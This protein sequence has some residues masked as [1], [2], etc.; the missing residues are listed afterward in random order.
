[1]A[2]FRRPPRRG[3]VRYEENALQRFFRIVL[4]GLL[5]TGVLWG[6]WMN[7]ERQ[8]NRVMQNAAPRIDATGTLSPAQLELL[9]TYGLRF[10]AEYGIR[11]QVEVRNSALSEAQAKKTGSMYLGLNPQSGQALFYAPPLAAAAL[12]EEFIRRLNQEHFSAYFAAGNW[13]QG[14]AEALSMI[15][16]R[17]DATLKNAGAGPADNSTATENREQ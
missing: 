12:G 13:P 7:S 9:Q 3:R 14:L 2:L 1:M 17:L 15:S 6:F 10:F 16:T 11:I 4:I 5:F 8:M